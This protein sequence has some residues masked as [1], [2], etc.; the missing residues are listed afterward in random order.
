MFRLFLFTILVNGIYIY[1]LSFLGNEK[2][3]LIFLDN[4]QINEVNVNFIQPLNRE[5]SDRPAQ[6]LACSL[7]Q[8]C[9]YLKYFYFISFKKQVLP[10]TQNDKCGWNRRACMS[11]ENS[12]KNERLTNGKIL[13]KVTIDQNNQVKWPMMFI[14]ISTPTISV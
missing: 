5:F 13:L 1:Y 7:A 10:L 4:G 3:Q 8:V 14:H 11:L 12:M 6:A 9:F 2:A